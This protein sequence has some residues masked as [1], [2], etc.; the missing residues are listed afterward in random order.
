MMGGCSKKQDQ[1]VSHLCLYTAAKP[2]P[3]CTRAYSVSFDF[4]ELRFCNRGLHSSREAAAYARS[5]AGEPGRC[6]KWYGT[7][8]SLRQLRHFRGGH[9]QR[10]GTALEGRLESAVVISRIIRERHINRASHP[11][12]VLFGW[13]YAA[14]RAQSP[15]LQRGR[16]VWIG[17]LL[18][19]NSAA[20]EE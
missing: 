11:Q 12:G 2:A 9:G 14:Y 8:Q 1:T 20:Q 19:C 7:A 10:R 16:E 13:R 6:A 5:S 3:C 17:R 15:F 4:A 18:P